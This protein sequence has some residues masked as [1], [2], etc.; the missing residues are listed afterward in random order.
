VFE[1]D[2]WIELLTAL[3]VAPYIAGLF[4]LLGWFR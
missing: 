2:A 3:L 1:I 4:L